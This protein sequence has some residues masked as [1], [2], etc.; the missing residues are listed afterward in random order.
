MSGR[1]KMSGRNVD[2]VRCQRFGWLRVKARN[3]D[4]F[5]V[6]TNLSAA[7]LLD[8]ESR[9]WRD[10]VGSVEAWAKLAASLSGNRR[11][12]AP[13]VGVLVEL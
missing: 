10:G 13:G 12:P 7:D 1:A 9:L 3:G 6:Y 2:A 4:V 11:Q 8:T 5:D